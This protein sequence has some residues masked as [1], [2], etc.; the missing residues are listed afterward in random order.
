MAT[1]KVIHFIVGSNEPRIHCEG[2][3]SH[4]KQGSFKKK[5]SQLQRVD[6]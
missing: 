3:E 4:T 5:A 6:Q 1:E 2:R